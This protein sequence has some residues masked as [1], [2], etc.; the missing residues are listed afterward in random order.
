M[1][2]PPPPPPAAH[3]TCRPGRTGELVGGCA[4]FE[5]SQIKTVRT[6]SLDVAV[7]GGTDG[8]RATMDG[9]RMTTVRNDFADLLFNEA[10]MQNIELLHLSLSEDVCFNC[11][12]LY[13]WRLYSRGQAYQDLGIIY[14]FERRIGS[15]HAPCFRY[16]DRHTFASTIHHERTPIFAAAANRTTSQ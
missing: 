1:R 14:H 16:N 9:T 6:G 12:R 10:S 8:T 4:R 15:R 13:S 3:F 5:E 7:E 11:W 2:S